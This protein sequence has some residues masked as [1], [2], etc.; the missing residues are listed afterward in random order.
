MRLWRESSALSPLRFSELGAMAVLSDARA[1]DEGCD[2]VDSRSGAL[3]R[4]PAHHNQVASDLVPDIPSHFAQCVLFGEDYSQPRCEVI[5]PEM[6]TLAV[7]EEGRVDFVP[8]GFTSLADWPHRKPRLLGDAFDGDQTA[9][10]ASVAPSAA[11]IAS[12]TTST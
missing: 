6:R 9:R 4:C 8:Y 1:R 5:P 2:V 10:S 7:H 12:I 11:S 3:E